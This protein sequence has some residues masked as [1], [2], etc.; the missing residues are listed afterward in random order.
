MNEFNKISKYLKSKKLNQ[1]ELENSIKNISK[2]NEKN[3]WDS[4]IDEAIGR[5]GFLQPFHVDE[6]LL[7]KNFKV[8]NKEIKNFYRN[9]P[10][11]FKEL[12]K[13]ILNNKSFQKYFYDKLVSWFKRQKS[14]T[15][16]VKEKLGI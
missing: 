5:N 13:N 3:I 4:L 8:F 1:V 12:D 11:L 16:K 15:T 6:I 9:F 10:N 7:N 14:Q 2:A